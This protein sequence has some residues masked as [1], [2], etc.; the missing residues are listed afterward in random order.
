MQVRSFYNITVRVTYIN[1][2]KRSADHAPDSALS[3]TKRQVI[4]V[5]NTYSVAYVIVN[6]QDINDNAPLFNVPVYPVNAA[7]RPFLVGAVSEAAEAN[8]VVLMVDVTDADTG[9][10][11]L[12][13]TALLNPAGAPFYLDGSAAIHT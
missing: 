4:D 13:T 2:G 10:N 7:Q 11:G 5:T 3:R 12:V 1:I 9:T 8:T 6:V